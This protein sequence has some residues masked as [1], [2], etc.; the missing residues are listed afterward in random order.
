MILCL[1]NGLEALIAESPSSP[2]ITVQAWIKA[3][4]ADEMTDQHGVSHFLE[5][6][7]LSR[8][9]QLSSPLYQL[10]QSGALI[11]GT[12]SKEHTVYSITAQPE[13]LLLALQVL[14]EMLHAPF[15]DE[16]MV[17]RERQIIYRELEMRQSDPSWLLQEGLHRQLWGGSAYAHPILGTKESLSRIGHSQ[18][19]RF[20]H[21]YYTP[22]HLLLV[23]AGAPSSKP[24]T[25]TV[26]GLFSRFSRSS[27]TQDPHSVKMAEPD[28][29]YN[30][31]Q[32][33]Q[34][35][36]THHAAGM[37]DCEQSPA[38]Q[39]I[40]EAAAEIVR[41]RYGCTLERSNTRFGGLSKLGW[42]AQAA[43][44]ASDPSIMLSR[45]SQASVS[46]EEWETLRIHLQQQYEK[47]RERI[48]AKALHDG[49]MWLY[50]RQMD[51]FE[52]Y[53]QMLR[54]IQPEQ[55]EQYL[56][57]W[58]QAVQAAHPRLVQ[59]FALQMSKKETSFRQKTL[60]AD[61]S[62]LLI[63]AVPDTAMTS[64][65]VALPNRAIPD[66][67]RLSALPHALSLFWMNGLLRS[68]ME[69]Q[70][71]SF[72]RAGLSV[73]PLVKEDCFGLQISVLTE[74][75]GEVIDR[76]SSYVC[77]PAF[78]PS[79]WPNIQQ[80][81]RSQMEAR[82]GT[83]F[84]QMQKAAHSAMFRGHAYEHAI[85]GN[86]E[87]ARQ[88]AYE[89]VAENGLAAF[90]SPMII[91]VYG[92]IP[93]FAIT[94]RFARQ[95][96]NRP[97]RS[98]DPE[99]LPAPTV[100]PEHP[101]RLHYGTRGQQAHLLIQTPGVPLTSRDKFALHIIGSMLTGKGGR[102]FSRLREERQ[103]AYSFTV[104]SKEFLEAG[105]ANGYAVCPKEHLETVEQTLLEE[106]ERLAYH[107]IDA[108]EMHRARER[109]INSFSIKGQAKTS[110]AYM[111]LLYEMANAGDTALP[112][113]AGQIRAVTMEQI[114]EAAKR[115]FLSQ[116][117]VTVVL[118]PI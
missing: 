101:T 113:Y 49:L 62:R 9:E 29:L 94:E 68:G 98:T 28:M 84:E 32:L 53:R 54:Q 105:Y 7:F 87:S 100:M 4:S 45:V 74:Q 23:I 19:A 102:L 25:D 52:R 70:E 5:H 58:G 31:H 110:K 55:I 60:L 51:S 66:W 3:G 36:S 11:N 104:F 81:L 76:L 99:L 95:W 48:E 79:I 106:W 18:L 2:L 59:P 88:L 118:T 21:R 103:L 33:T 112:D 38:G 46:L 39:I 90:S 61:Q 16:A 50:F 97:A 1:E 89:Q 12:T 107:P 77:S 83:F 26:I 47:K 91:S 34:G 24:L 67:P 57:A 114:Q 27:G 75:L 78:P 93:N 41:K 71:S 117:R 86:D 111:H 8:R 69:G 10:E 43:A 108:T 14:A 64:V 65:V 85:Y 20:Y 30:H 109:L 22:D 82:A 17:E 40:A 116:Q 44:A 35:S 42:T 37:L 92:G 115:Y 13:Q 96:H 80:T 15:W 63:H 72:L 73:L 56:S 6:L